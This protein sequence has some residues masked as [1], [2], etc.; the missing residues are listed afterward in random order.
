MV[1]LPLTQPEETSYVKVQLP[2]VC[3]VLRPSSQG[4]WSAGPS[5]QRAGGALEVPGWATLSYY[6]ALRGRPSGISH[7]GLALLT[8]QGLGSFPN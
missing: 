7:Q 1:G 5:A 2:R 3:S 4:A 6:G 8:C